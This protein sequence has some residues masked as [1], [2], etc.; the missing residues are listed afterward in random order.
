MTVVTVTTLTLSALILVLVVWG[1][2]R[3]VTVPRPRRWGVLGPRVYCASAELVEATEEAIG[4]WQE[5]GHDVAWAAGPGSASV[6]IAVDRALDD[7]DSVDDI[8]PSRLGLTRTWASSSGLTIR[9]EIGVVPGASAVVIAHE[10]GHALGYEHPF[11]PPSGHLMHPTR[12]GWNGRGL[13]GP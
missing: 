1:R 9:S 7:R 6:T 13:Q 5:R 3:K 12:P 4:W 10:L 8:E 2:F 11:F